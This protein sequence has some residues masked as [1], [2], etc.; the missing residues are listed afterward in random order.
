MIDIKSIIRKAID[1]AP[2]TAIALS[3]GTTLPQYKYII[4]LKFNSASNGV[5]IESVQVADWNTM[6]IGTEV[7]N[8]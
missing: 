6:E 7:Y 4:T 2:V 8:W 1:A 3:N 5:E